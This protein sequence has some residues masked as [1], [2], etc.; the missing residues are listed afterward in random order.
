[1][2]RN[3]HP[4]VTVGKI[5]EVS[6]RLFLEKGYDNTKIQDI[7]DE[8]GMTKGAIY[9]HFESKEEIMNKLG[10]TMF[11]HNNPFEIV[12]KRNDLNGLEKMKLAIKL[13]QSNEQMVELTNQALPLL[14]NPQILAKMFESNYQNLL[15]YWL[16]LIQ[17]GQEDGSIK[18]E[19]PKELAELFILTD[20]LMIPSLF[21]G[22]AD[23]IK[24]R[25]KFV[26]VML[27]KMGL[28]LYDEEMIEKIDQLPYYK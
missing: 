17:E 8:L 23:D 13:N 1:M 19:Q 5:L 4:E 27:G 21:P 16:E 20:L 12:K 3:K 22:N 25:Y 15:P 18:T 11:I 2:A 7:A 10:E 6:K 24:N 28:P 14:E 9:H 26:T